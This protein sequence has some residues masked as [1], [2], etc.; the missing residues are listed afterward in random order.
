MG[1]GKLFHEYALKGIFDEEGGREKGFVTSKTKE[2]KYGR[3]NTDWGA[4]LEEDSLMPDNK[5]V[6][7]VV[8]R[9]NKNYDKPFFMGLGFLRP[10]VPLYVPQ[11]W[12]DLHPLEGIKVPPYLTDD[13]N[14]IP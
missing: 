5:S 4:F 9:F 8:E 10:H 2:K 11:R 7:W 3:I 12:F 1:I 13:L 6:N 14:D